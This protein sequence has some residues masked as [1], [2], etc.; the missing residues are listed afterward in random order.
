MCIV[1]DMQKLTL[2]TMSKFNYIEI[3]TN[4]NTHLKYKEHYILSR[5]KCLG[6]SH[7]MK[8]KEIFIIK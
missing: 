8:I 2:K 4:I 5:C 6:G 1:G 7:S 3:Q